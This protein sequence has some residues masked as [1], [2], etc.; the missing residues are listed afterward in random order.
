MPTGLPRLDQPHSPQEA[1]RGRFVIDLLV[2]HWRLVASC[3]TVGAVAGAAAGMVMHEVRNEYAAQ[4]DLVVKP[5]YWQS[6]ALSTLDTNV[7]GETTPRTLVNR[8]DTSA[9]AR[10][11][12]DGLLQDDLANG[13]AG[14]ELTNDR[15]LDARAAAIE[16]SIAI[17]PYDEKGVLRVVTYS[18]TG[19]DEALRLA[20][21][22]ARALIDHT[23]LQRLDEQVQAYSAVLQQID[24]SRTQLDEAESQQWNYREQMGFRT[25]EQVWEDI[26]LKNGELQDALGMVGEL[27][28]R[29]AEIDQQLEQNS[30]RIP[31]VLG[32]VT[33]AV[34]QDLLEQLDELRSEEL[35]LSVVWKPG[36][37]ELDRLQAE[38]DEKKE[39]VLMAIG[40]LRGGTGGSGLWEER[41]ELYRQKLDLKSQL[42]SYSVRA[43]SLRSTVEEY[44]KSLPQLADQSFEYTQLAHESAQLRTQ[45]DKL[46]EKEF[47]LRTAMRRGTA[48][49]ERRSAPILLP[50]SQGRSAP[51]TAWT[52]IG[53]IIGLVGSLGFTMLREMSNTSIRSVA[54][55]SHYIKIEVIGTIPEMRFSNARATKRRK[56]AYVVNTREAEVEPSVVTQ[57]DPKSPVSEAYRSLRTNF[58]FATLQHEPRT[59]MVTSSVPAE[60]KTTTA[61]NFAVTMADLGKRVVLVDTDLRRPN[62]HHVLRMQREKGLADVLRGQASLADVI[63]PTATGNLWMISSGRVP[64]NPSELIGG[65]G[66]AKVMEA[67][68]G[69]FDLVVCDAPST[70]VVTD[71]V[72]LATR[73]ESVLLVIAANRAR[74]ETI[75]RAVKVLESTNTPI[76]G[77]VLNGIKATARHYYYY[78]YYYDDRTRERRSRSRPIVPAAAGGDRY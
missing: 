32:N 34:V 75:Q 29:I 16:R 64:P 4:A 37:P 58:Q 77:V 9:L 68:R 48:T 23:Q 69:Q 57:H 46:L 78:Y 61:V 67:L 43:A 41:Q 72:V 47:E 38:I 35:E 70:L 60:G 22:T 45:F 3:V 28:G 25:H 39:A 11:V 19:S 55:V 44:S 26:E 13:R 50:A 20:E 53:G 42:M 15:E 40:E 7:F 6:P 10:D 54:D 65:E 49:V 30:A 18:T 5:S 63:R 1:D 24:E 33:E 76:A 36:Y 73:V 56:A 27:S 71:P 21:Y 14:G 66:M 17:E 52:M 74:R 51:L 62:V 2:R 59:I 12:V 31:E 8:L